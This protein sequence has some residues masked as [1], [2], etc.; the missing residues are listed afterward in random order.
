MPAVSICIPTYKQIECLNTCLDSVLVQDFKDFELIISDDTPDDSVQL[1]IEEKL[2]GVQYTY[3]HHK[4]SLGSPANW[5]FAIGSAKGDFIK[6]MHHDDFFSSSK[7]LSL[8]VER[9]QAE[10]SDFL[11]T[12]AHVIYKRGN[13]QRIQVTTQKQLCILQKDPSF[14]FFKNVIM[15]PSATLYRNVKAKFDESLVWLVDIDFYIRKMKEGKFSYI[16]EPLISL[17][18]NVEGQISDQVLFN[19]QIQIKEHV[20]VFNK[21]YADIKDFKPYHQF[22]DYLFSDFNLQS[23]DELIAIATMAQE[24]S[25][26]FLGVV[27]DLNRNRKLKS[28]IRRCYGSRYNNYVFKLEQFHPK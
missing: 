25:D 10:Q 11:Y 4:P 5:N 13:T 21:L 24:N 9:I 18:H 3:F 27:K 2:K 19:K 17:V 23:Y 7:S 16:D 14:L 28:F 8:M 6:I 20:L 1:Y 26:F 22:F 15:G 12:S